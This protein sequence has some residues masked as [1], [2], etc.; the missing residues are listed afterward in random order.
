MLFLV[1]FFFC[2]CHIICFPHTELVLR[3]VDSLNCV[4]LFASSRLFMRYTVS[5]V[6]RESMYRITYIGTFLYNIWL[7][8]LQ[9]FCHIL[10]FMFPFLLFFAFLVHLI[11]Y[12]LLSF[13]LNLH[14]RMYGSSHIINYAIS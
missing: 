7:R 6:S 3:L 13:T 10:C 9:S 8:S 11:V 1:F 14:F 4:F 5:Y 12:L 2:L